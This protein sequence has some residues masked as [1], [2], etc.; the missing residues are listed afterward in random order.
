MTLPLDDG[1]ERVDLL[2]P[3]FRERLVRFFDDPEIKGRFTVGSAAR[4]YA[5][6]KNLQIGWLKRL[7]GYNLAAD[8]DQVIGRTP[9]GWVAKGS[10]HMVQS[11]G[12][13]YGVDLSKPWWM[14]KGSA[15]TI[16]DRVA[17]RYGLRRT[18]PSEWWHL[19]PRNLGGWFDDPS[20][21]P[22]PPIITPAT[23]GLSMLIA[24]GYQV[25]LDEGW[26][27]RYLSNPK[28]VERYKASG[29]PLVDLSG[30]FDDPESPAVGWAHLRAEARSQGRLAGEPS[31]VA[32]AWDAIK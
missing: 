17:P 32:A 27:Y 20:A 4:T 14:T 10:W 19:Q 26:R 5:Q 8:P 25:W 30:R 6:Q 1:N 16:I 31:A 23:R 13:A 15:Q 9:E 11:D 29:L 12:W 21:P 24:V 28:V 18:V 22:P 7:R 2:H 3:R